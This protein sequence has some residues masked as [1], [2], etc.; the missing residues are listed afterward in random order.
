VFLAVVFIAEAAEWRYC[1][2]YR[3]VYS[4]VKGTLLVLNQEEEVLGSIC[5]I[6]PFS[7]LVI[8]LRSSCRLK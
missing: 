8:N 3:K 1:R 6:V 5:C 7:F 4:G 2:A